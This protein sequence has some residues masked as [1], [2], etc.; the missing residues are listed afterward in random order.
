MHGVLNEISAFRY[1]LQ[2]LHDA[3]KETRS[4]LDEIE[5][6]VRDLLKSDEIADAVAAKVNATNTLKLT[7]LQQLVGIGIGL[8]TIAAGLKVLVGL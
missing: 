7:F 4:R 8:T 6:Q 3:D 1:Q 2:A 5:G